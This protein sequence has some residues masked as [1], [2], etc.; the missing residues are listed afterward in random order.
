MAMM[1]CAGK[2]AQLAQGV[3][4]GLLIGQLVTVD[5]VTL[6]AHPIRPLLASG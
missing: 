1:S 5:A 3:I 6:L 2:A 4:G